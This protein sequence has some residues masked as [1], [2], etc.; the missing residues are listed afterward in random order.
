MAPVT[1]R[2][3]A[4]VAGGSGNTGWSARSLF[5]APVPEIAVNMIGLSSSNAGFGLVASNNQVA[6][7]FTP[8]SSFS[9]A[10]M[11]VI[12]AKF[13]APTDNWFV[14]IQTNNAGLPSG[15]PVTNGTSNSYAGTALT[16]TTQEWTITWSTPPS[17]SSGTKYWAVFKRSGSL[18]GSNAYVPIR[19]GADRK[20]VV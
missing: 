16:T 5:A 4:N 11:D 13:G 2:S 12:I 8:G 6:Q 19:T 15:T 7:S 14:E 3:T 20:S 10:R 18:D 9:L 1:V 17:L